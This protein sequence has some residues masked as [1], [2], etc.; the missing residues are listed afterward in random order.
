MN[1]P[2]LEKDDK[3]LNPDFKT[4]VE[5]REEGIKRWFGE[6]GVESRTVRSSADMTYGATDEAFKGLASTMQN[7]DV[8]PDHLQG[9]MNSTGVPAGAS[10]SKDP[11]CGLSPA[12][13]VSHIH[14]WMDGCLPGIS[15]YRG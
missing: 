4:R 9:L 15:R 2:S 11:L 14:G 1:D 8:S 7:S 10:S 3:G 13:K 5:W 6:V 12:K